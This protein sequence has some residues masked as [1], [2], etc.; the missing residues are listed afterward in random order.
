MIGSQVHLNGAPFTVIGVAPPT[1]HGSY[2]ALATDLWVPLMTYDTVR[3]RGL[4]ITRRGWGWLSATARLA[5]GVTAD[6]AQA[7]VDRATRTLTAEFPRENAGLA[8]T[9]VPALALPEEMGPTVRRVLLFALAVAGLAL[10]AAC[11]NIANVQLATV[12]DR[13]REIAMRRALGATRLRIA[14]QWLTESLVVTAVAAA[15]GSLGAMSQGSAERYAQGDGRPRDKFV[16]EGVEGRVPFKGRLADYVYQLVGG[17]RSGMGY[18]G[19]R[20]VAE[21]NTETRFV[22]VTA[23]GVQESQPHDIQITKEAPNYRVEQP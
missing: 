6:R 14:R 17:L 4:P 16:P 3:P 8:F 22:R 23:A 7:A 1:F 2:D 12:F 5:P 20:T 15:V 11:A 18:C 13:A 10:V 19:C 9:I 21:L